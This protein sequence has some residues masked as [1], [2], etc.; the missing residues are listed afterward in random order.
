VFAAG[1][2]ESAGLGESAQAEKR[3][4]IGSKIDTEGALLG[5]MMKLL[6]ENAGFTVV[7]RIQTGATPIVRS[8]II[9]GEIDIYPEYTGNGYYFFPDQT[10]AA[11]WKNRESAWQ[12]IKELD[13]EANNIVWLPPA[14]AN[15]TWAIALRRDVAQANDLETLEDLAAYINDGGSFKI[16]ASEEFVSSEAALPSFEAGYGFKLEDDQMLVLSGGNTTLTEKAAATGQDGVNAAMA[17]GTDGQLAA[18]GLVV[19]EDTKQIQPVYEPAPIIRKSVLEKY[20]E[21]EGILR[22][23]FE[24][25][26]LTTLQEL[27][28]A[29]SVEGKSPANV[30]NSYLTEKGFLD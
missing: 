6:L 22:P 2:G 18:L 10:D 24:S 11:L 25:L 30:A 19:M 12:K 14:P 15:N 20:P 1:T 7:D 17:Y 5:N 21:I 16:A 28:S 27:N 9:S 23:A 29:I 3:I 26:S 8:A 4:T 13:L